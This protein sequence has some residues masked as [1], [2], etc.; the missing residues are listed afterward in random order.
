[1]PA[2][3]KFNVEEEEEEE[4]EEEGE[5]QRRGGGGGDSTSRRRRRRFN[6]GRLVGLNNSPTSG[7]L[8]GSSPRICAR[9]LLRMPSARGLH[10]S[11]FRLNVSAFCVIGGGIWGCLGGV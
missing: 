6:V 10:S 8:S 11:T 1:M 7:G 4:E 3:R 2:R 9:I 5:I